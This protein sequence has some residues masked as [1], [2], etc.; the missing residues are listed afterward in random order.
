MTRL[1]S[2]P[3]Q[4]MERDDFEQ[5]LSEQPLRELPQ[6]WRN[7]ILSTA[8]G[9]NSG[10]K[11]HSRID[12]PLFR[13][14]DLRARF[15]ALLWPAPRAWAG[16]AFIWLLLAIA[17]RI[18]SNHESNIAL[19]GSRPAPAAMAAWKEQERILVELIQPPEAPVPE[20]S[21][22]VAPQPRSEVLG[23]FRTI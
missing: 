7:R 21:R 13:M 22:H 10:S 6:E 4:N 23:P 12:P 2:N 1:N 16:L 8:Q 15:A 5:K 18:P 14:R 17:N 19:T 20:A 11:T 3:T 9:A